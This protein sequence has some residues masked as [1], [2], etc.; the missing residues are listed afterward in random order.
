MKDNFSNQS[1]LYAK[2]R[3]SYPAALFEFI[4]SL[5]PDKQSAWDCGT[6]NGQIAGVLAD[7]FEIVYATDISKNQLANAIIFF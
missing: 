7:S 1:F 5:V 3:P 6:G 2:F 4:L